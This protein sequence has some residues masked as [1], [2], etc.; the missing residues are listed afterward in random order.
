[1]IRHGRLED[2]DQLVDIEKSCFEQDRISRRSFRH[3]LTKGRST[4][5]VAEEA[6]NLTGYV[7]I[8]FNRGTSLAR[9]YSIAIAQSHRHSGIA[10]K[11]VIAGES[12]A[13]E[14]NCI[15]MRLEVRDDNLASIRLF[16]SMGYRQFGRYLKYYEDDAD[17]V[18]LEKRLIKN[19]PHH[20]TNVHY[21][22]QTLE[23]TCGPASLMMAMKTLDK[24]IELSRQIELRLWRE[25]TSIYMTSGHG[26]CGPYGLA[27]AAHRR[28]FKVVVYVKDK[29]TTLFVDSVRSK[30][31][32]EVI[33]LV[34]ED[35]LK[36]MKSSGVQI[37]YQSV[38]T[39]EI[40]AALDSGA[41][42]V[43]LI[44]SYRLYQEK[45]PHWVVMTGHDE[46]FIYFHDPYID[47]EKGKTVTDSVNMPIAQQEFERMA[48]YGKSGQRAAL[49]IYPK[50][51]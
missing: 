45:F 23:F 51:R 26:G 28:G 15:T 11:L 44:S 18:R 5:L 14:H 46:H 35:F 30:D 3:L 47:V 50:V 25:S 7:L 37:N 22:H 31:K 32:K 34:E 19:L 41:V 9:L 21:Y 38:T 42:P 48:R 29:D 6:G 40:I 13:V 20:F 1:M 4:V 33:R 24:R 43:V 12:D 39:N 36:E 10:R 27:L 16:E 17:A 49:I 8:L 2:I